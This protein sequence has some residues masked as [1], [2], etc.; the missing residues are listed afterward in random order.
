MA[1]RMTVVPS[2]FGGTSNLV[3]NGMK[4][5][6]Y[7]GSYVARISGK[8]SKCNFAVLINL[9]QLHLLRWHMKGKKK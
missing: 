8:A 3:H 5:D 9:K 1:C 2:A 4:Y 6:I 7:L